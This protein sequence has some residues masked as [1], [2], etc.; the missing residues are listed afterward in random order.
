M[1]LV[2]VMYV[3]NYCWPEKTPQLTT[4]VLK[5]VCCHLSMSRQ[6]II[7]SLPLTIDKHV[8]CND[9]D[10]ELTKLVSKPFHDTS[11]YDETDDAQ[12]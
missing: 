9:S 6:Y 4:S 1:A 11:G 10:Q 7:F 3:I 2:Q 12:G 5:A 8:I